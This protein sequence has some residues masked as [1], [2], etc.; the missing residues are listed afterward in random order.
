LSKEVRGVDVL[1][2]LVAGRNLWRVFSAVPAGPS[3]DSHQ[4]RSCF[5]LIGIDWLSGPITSARISFTAELAYASRLP[6]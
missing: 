1:W 4:V 6:K 2:W 5:A 3:P